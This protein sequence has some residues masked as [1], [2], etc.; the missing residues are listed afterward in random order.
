MP[1]LMHVKNA[2]Q[3]KNNRRTSFYKIRRLK[4]EIYQCP[5]FSSQFPK[6]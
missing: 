2:G 3:R 4:T 6:I 1:L 5:V